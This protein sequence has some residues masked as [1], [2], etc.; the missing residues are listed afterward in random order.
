MKNAN[1]HSGQTVIHVVQHLAPGG[2]ESLALDLLAFSTPL[3]RVMIVSLEGEK[4][5]AIEKWPR[6]KPFANQLHFLDKKPGVKLQTLSQLVKMFNAV[7]PDVVHTH[8][9]GPLLYAG[10][11]SRLTSVPVR[12]HTEHDVWHLN[13]DKHLRLEKMALDVA[14]P[15]L[16]ADANLVEETLLNHF[17][18]DQ[19][20][21]IKNGVDCEKFAPGSKEVARS[22]FNL[23]QDKKIIGCAGRLETVKG[24][25]LAIAA[26][27]YMPKSVHLVIAGHGSQ[28]EQLETIA[29]QY[30]V[31]DRV[32][33]LGLVDDMQRFYQS[34]DLFCMPSRSEGFPLSPL[35]AQSCNIRTAVTNVGASEETL[36]PESGMLIRANDIHNMAEVLFHMLCHAV[37]TQPRQFVIENNDI[38]NMVKAY[39]S[40]AVQGQSLE[41]LA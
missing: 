23:P 2:L 21:T 16:V 6:L 11:A 39:E 33:F 10:L 19:T 35:E 25:D 27:S 5:Q 41:A 29:N 24:H 34:L 36:C 12:I 38:R 7:K 18:Y 20:T 37:E 17:S 15:Q 32:T 22:H 8:H 3:N 28:R 4:Q 14:K 26:L 13:N 9:I 30:N 40:L 31:P 1:A